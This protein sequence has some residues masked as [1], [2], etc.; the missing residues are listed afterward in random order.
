MKVSAQARRRRGGIDDLTEIQPSPNRDTRGD[1]VTLR[2][3]WP[4]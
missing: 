2:L 4:Q 3:L 1:G